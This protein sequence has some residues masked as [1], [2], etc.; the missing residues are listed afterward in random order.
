MA[1]TG[2]VCVAT[3]ILS[4]PAEAAHKTLLSGTYRPANG[5]R[6][7]PKGRALSGRLAVRAYPRGPVQRGHRLCQR[8]PLRIETHQLL[9]DLGGLF[10][11]GEEHLIV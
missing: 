5:T 7:T 4:G 9:F 2:R 1:F 10:A 6:R 11:A 8:L 3:N